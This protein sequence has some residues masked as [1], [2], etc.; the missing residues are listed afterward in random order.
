MP[1]PTHTRRAR[2]SVQETDVYA[3]DSVC[4][5][6]AVCGALAGR[7]CHASIGCCLQSFRPV[8]LPSSPKGMWQ[9]TTDYGKVCIG[10]I[11]TSTSN[12]PP[13]GGQQRLRPLQLPL[14]SLCSWTDPAA[15]DSSHLG[16]PCPRPAL[17][18]WG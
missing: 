18:S 16:T 7:L 14:Q 9:R 2:R 17:R 1:K 13:C 12:Q 11:I 6:Y 15:E 5:A 3:A 10:I 4:V 8:V